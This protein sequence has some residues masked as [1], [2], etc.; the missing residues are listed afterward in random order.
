MYLCMY[1]YLSIYIYRCTVYICISVSFIIDIRPCNHGKFFFKNLRV[2]TDLVTITLRVR[3]CCLLNHAWR[4][5]KKIYES[6]QRNAQ[7]HE[8]F[9]GVHPLKALCDAEKNSELKCNI[10][11]KKQKDSMWCSFTMGQV[12]HF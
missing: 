1:V 3:I 4:E 10:N 2:G 11:Q 7:Q 5:N 12:T 8:T 9:Q 6:F